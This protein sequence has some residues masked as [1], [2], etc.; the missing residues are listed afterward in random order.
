MNPTPQPEPM[1]CIE[2]VSEHELDEAMDL[3]YGNASLEDL[4]EFR[5]AG[6]R[7]GHA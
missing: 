7:L 6:V 1:P 3:I 2:E 4:R 5:K